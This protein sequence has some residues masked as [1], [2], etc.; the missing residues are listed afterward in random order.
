MRDGC[1]AHLGWNART[2]HGPGSV[3]SLYYLFH[4]ISSCHCHDVEEEDDE[5]ANLL[6]S[7]TTSILLLLPHLIVTVSVSRV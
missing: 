7:T 6:F 1:L 3:L 4:H 2:T 5:D